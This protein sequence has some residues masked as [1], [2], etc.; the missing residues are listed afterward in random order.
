MTETQIS[1]IRLSSK[2]SHVSGSTIDSSKVGAGRPLEQFC[3]PRSLFY[4]IA[5]PRHFT[6]GILS[7]TNQ[8]DFSQTIAT[9]EDFG[10]KSF[11]FKFQSK[12]IQGFRS[13]WFSKLH[14]WSFERRVHIPRQFGA[15]TA[16]GRH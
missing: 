3:P 1:P 11:G 10:I 2:D 14:P 12:N 5:T 16:D 4:P 15:T 9:I 13:N 6:R 7:C 8:R